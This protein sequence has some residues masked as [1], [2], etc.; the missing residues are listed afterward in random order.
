LRSCPGVNFGTFFFFVRIVAP[1]AGLRALPA[2][3]TLRSK[4]PKPV[5]ATFSP[6][7]TSRVMVSSTDSRAC[8]ACLRFPSKRADS[9]STSCDLFTFFPSDERSGPS[10]YSTAC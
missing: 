3:R 8:A 4:E 9:L 1:V 6:R 10:F 7:A 5:M 2:L